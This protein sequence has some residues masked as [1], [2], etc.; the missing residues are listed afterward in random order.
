MKKFLKI[1]LITSL[2]IFAQNLISDKVEAKHYFIHS[3]YTENYR[4][5]NSGVKKSVYIDSDNIGIYKVGG[6]FVKD[7]NTEKNGYFRVRVIEIWDWDIATTN[8]P[9]QQIFEKDYY[10]FVKKVKPGFIM[11]YSLFGDFIGDIHYDIIKKYKIISSGDKDINGIHCLETGWKTGG[12]DAVRDKLVK[13][14]DNPSS[15]WYLLKIYNEARK[16]YGI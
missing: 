11:A 9:K 6:V 10:F 4:G 14:E 1:F 5:S 3:S 12:Q 8:R 13:S 16:I 2:I 7:K 15:D